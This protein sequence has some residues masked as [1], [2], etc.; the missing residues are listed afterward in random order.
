MTG[1]TVPE[2]VDEGY[3]FVTGHYNPMEGEALD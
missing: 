3:K 1:F 2:K